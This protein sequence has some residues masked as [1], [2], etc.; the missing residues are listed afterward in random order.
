MKSYTK[1]KVD[2]DD[3]DWHSKLVNKDVNETCLKYICVEE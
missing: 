1:S 2:K 3:S